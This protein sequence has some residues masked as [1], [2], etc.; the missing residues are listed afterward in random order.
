[1]KKKRIVIALGHEALG[2]TLPEQQK[3]AARTAKAVADF[4]REDY[5]VV[6]THSNGPQ[7]GMIH[8]AMNEFCRLYPEYTATPTSVCSAMSQGYIGYDLQNAI[9]T[10]LLNR[11]IYKTVSTVL[12][13]VVVDP[14]DE[15]FYHPTK[16]IGRVMTK[17]EAEE[18]EKKGNHVTEVEGGYRRIVASPKPMDIVEI[19]AISALSDADQ[20]VI[21][22]GGGGIPVL[23]QNNRLQGASAV[24]EKDLAAG[25]LAEL[26]DADM[27][28][29]LTSVDKVCLNYG[30]EDEVKLDTLSLADAKKYLAAGEFGEGTMAPK[31][32]AAIDFIGESAIR[33][34]LV[35]KLNKEAGEITGGM[36]T[37]IKK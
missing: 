35:T 11:G 34:V 7:V 23:A 14:Y 21:A 24:I 20:V 19:D 9:R 18:E 8:T 27:L 6:I 16:V 3:A 29:I 28:V 10:E 33:S 5:Q 31:I 4:I 25:K 12:T 26:L 30:K 17:E 13:Q 36:G 22:C 1:M 32:E 15:A 2:S 37:L